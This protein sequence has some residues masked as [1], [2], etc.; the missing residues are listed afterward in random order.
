[1]SSL[2]VTKNSITS[3]APVASMTLLQGLL[4]GGNS[5]D[6]IDVDLPDSLTALY[7]NGNAITSLEPL[8]THTLQSLDVS[9]NPLTSLAPLFAMPALDTLTASD[10]G[11]TD[12]TAFPLAKLRVLVVQDNHITSVA[13][14]S[15][16]T[17][18][19]V[20][21]FG[22]DVVSLPPDF[23]GLATAC[24]GLVLLGNP[25]DAAA[26]ERLVWLCTQGGASYSWDGGS[27]DKCLRP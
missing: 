24:G 4:V 18:L 10:V 27:C 6:A 9:S 7:L 16:L 20:D 11:A 23:V 1:L 3:L 26:R 5:L 21:L 17:H 13:P 2:D 14:L 25:L 12:L 22:N 8:A 15:G 19:S